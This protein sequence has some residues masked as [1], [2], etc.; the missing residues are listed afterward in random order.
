[1]S[2]TR[3]GPHWAIGVDSDQYI[4]LDDL[5]R[6]SDSQDWQS[7]ILTSMVKRTDLAARAVISE[8]ARGVFLPGRRAFGL[9][10]GGVDIAYSGG[11]LDEIRS[12]IEDFRASIVAG[13]IQV[14]CLPASK[15][16]IEWTSSNAV[17]S[18]VP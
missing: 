15:R 16:P 17:A 18:C 8:Y 13:D 2:Q 1:M 14:P 10:E 9:A 11:F 4:R 7:H 5:P 6:S 12:S 3:V